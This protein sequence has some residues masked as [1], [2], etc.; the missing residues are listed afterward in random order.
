MP[1]GLAKFKRFAMEVWRVNPEGKSDKE[2]AEEGILAM[3]NWMRKLG[4]AMNLSALGAREDMIEGIAD[5]TFI[6]KGGYKILDRAEVVEI[7]KESM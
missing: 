5:A 4:V 7:L 2:I 1:F 6:L 3:E